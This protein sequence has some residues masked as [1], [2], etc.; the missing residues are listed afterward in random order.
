MSKGGRVKSK[1]ESKVKVKSEMEK[2][3]VSLIVQGAPKILI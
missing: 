3:Q 2:R 1:K